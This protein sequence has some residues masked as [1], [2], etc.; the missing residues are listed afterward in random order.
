MKKIEE[1][2]EKQLEELTV[3]QDLIFS[4]LSND[5]LAKQAL[6]VHTS[7]M[8]GVSQ[9][10]DNEQLKEISIK[11]L[12]SFKFHGK[13]VND[14]ISYYYDLFGEEANLGVFNLMKK[15]GLD[16]NYG[17]QDEQDEQEQTPIQDQE[18]K[19]KVEVNARKK[20]TREKEED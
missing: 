20:V 4:L 14:A 1:R 11:S 8:E 9:E 13:N 18:P 19:P 2:L 15:K 6:Q 7:V 5:Y 16:L 12:E 3:R 10:P 17:Q